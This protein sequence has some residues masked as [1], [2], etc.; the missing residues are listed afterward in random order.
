MTNYWIVSQLFY[1][2]ETST[3]YIM[4]KIAEMLG[5]NSNVNVI[6]GSSNY[7]SKN[8]NTQKDLKKEINVIKINTPSLNKN[9]IFLRIL[10]FFYFTF[11]VFFKILFKV[12]KNDTLI[13][14][15]NPPTLLVATAFLK[16][17]INF[18]LIII[19]QDIFPE[20]A[21]ISGI[22]NKKSV[23]YKFSLW[24]MNF[25][26]RKADKLIACGTDMAQHFISKGIEK[27]NI[28]VIP[29]WADQELIDTNPNINR[30]KYF[31]LDLT[32]KVVLA[33]A[34]NIGRVQGL[35]NFLKIFKMTNNKKLVLLIIGDG[36]NKKKLEDY[37]KENRI[38]NVHFFSSKPREQQLQ[39]LNCSDVGLVTLCEGMIG[40][41]VPS[42]VYNI[43][44]A[45]KPVLYI[46]DKNS[47][48]DNYIKLNEIGWSFKWDEEKR[49]IEF[50]N[51]IEITDN[52]KSLGL[53]ARNFVVNN[54]TE[55][56][57]L[58]QYKNILN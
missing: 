37:V 57:V 46:G 11:S 17:H 44:S 20:N 36:A 12:K 56:N 31:N 23:V 42:K 39:F 4:T 8:L 35:E 22:I 40:L 38:V 15:T 58:N 41:G 52:L 43:M 25:A 6:C 28:Y 29:N 19:L 26:Y 51:K 24:A 7:H 50:L 10:L 54:F 49:L 14:V 5:E 9:N 2:E 1:P 47:E 34:G 27:S 16:R 33:F 30:N 48:I 32:D 45:S 3:A 55:K 13:I 21:A 18:K 53:N